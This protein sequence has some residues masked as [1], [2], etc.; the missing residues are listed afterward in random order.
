MDGATNA[1]PSW[2]ATAPMIDV[3]TLSNHRF[4]LV[5]RDFGTITRGAVSPM[6]SKPKTIDLARIVCMPKVAVKTMAAVVVCQP[7]VM[8]R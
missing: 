1:T 5:H 7:S 3:S 8:I 2:N 6:Q 4:V